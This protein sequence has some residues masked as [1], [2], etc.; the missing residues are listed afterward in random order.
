MFACWDSHP[1]KSRMSVPPTHLLKPYAPVEVLRAADV[2]A[3]H[4]DFWEE[5]KFRVHGKWRDRV[6]TD[7]FRSGMTADKSQCITFKQLLSEYIEMSLRHPPK[8]CRA[9]QKALGVA[10]AEIKRWLRVGD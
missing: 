5:E 4:V 6:L 1:T 3:D 8:D 10:V 9:R 2:L 7:F